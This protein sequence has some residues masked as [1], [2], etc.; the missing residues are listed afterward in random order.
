MHQHH[1]SAKVPPGNIHS[2]SLLHILCYS[3]IPKWVQFII[4]FKILQTKPH[5]DILKKVCLKSLQIYKLKK[6]T[7]VYTIC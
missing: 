7:E 5:N 6:C 1:T 3:F 4:F 2:A